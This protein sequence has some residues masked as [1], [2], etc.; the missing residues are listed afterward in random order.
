MARQ[1]TETKWT[2]VW[3]AAIAVLAAAGVVLAERNH[4]LPIPPWALPMLALFG[5]FATM[6]IGL[7]QDLR[8]R[9]HVHRSGAWLAVGAWTTW[10]SIAGWSTSA[11]LTLAGSTVILTALTPL[12]RTPQPVPD[13]RGGA[14]IV[15]PPWDGQDRRPH[16]VR[17][18]ENLLRRLTR[19]PVD[20]SRVEPWAKPKDGCRVFIDLPA[21]GDLT[22]SDLAGI[23]E[24]VATAR[25]LPNGCSVRLLPGEH[26]GE[27]VLDVMLRDCLVDSVLLADD[28][29][30]ASVYDEF[31]VMTTPRGE[32]L[33]VCL[34]SQ[35]MVIGA[36]PD[37]G[38]TT[39]LH[40]IMLFLARC[41]DAV[42]WVADT[43]GGGAATPF[44]RP[45][46]LGLADRP[47]VDWV[48]ADEAEAAVMMAVAAA[49][50]KDRKTA[51]EA[52]RRRHDQ[53][54]T[55]LP[56]DRDLPAI[57]VLNDEGGELRQA[58]NL[59]GQLADQGVS[60]LAQIGR[61][62]AVR[63]I[64]SVL[65]GTSDLLDKGMRVCAAL[66][67]AL[68]MEEQ[69][70]YEHILGVNPGKTTLT[71][72]GTG[73]IRRPGDARPIHGRTVN[74]LLSQ[75]ERAAVACA[76][77]RPPLDERAR[78]AAARVRA[79]DV[80]GGKDPRDFPD[81]MS[82]PALA[83][84]QLGRAYEG[85]WDRFADRL[86]AMRGED[87]PEVDDEPEPAPATELMATASAPP[88]GRAIAHL[89]DVSGVS[90]DATT[91]VQPTAAVAGHPEPTAAPV[92]TSHDEESADVLLAGLEQPKLTTREHIVMI[93][94]D[95][96]PEALT[97]GQIGAELER[98]TGST[99]DRTHRQNLLKDMLERGQILRVEESA[100]GGRYTVKR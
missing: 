72:K 93:L 21:T 89:V 42:I 59:L 56:V 78:R 27:A 37:M 68:R 22:P 36:A 44:V 53:D 61:A 55:V 3:T 40:R 64:K 16:G 10:V 26:Q 66:R 23:V 19:Q 35:S 4:L 84:A 34:R 15:T 85:R 6:L 88:T 62:E 71:H 77:L 32:A 29:T 2:P 86:A 14:V 54:T 74:V 1:Q 33:T 73:F 51:P 17:E 69:D 70:E 57:V 47:L 63:V 91:P 58:A 99:G 76:H 13:S 48:A 79:R 60:R 75:I 38:K 98:R 87:V 92:Q 96:H 90:H 20:V 30:P 45:W 11:W 28:F 39:L 12:C 65:R 52:V 83:D 80:L 9:T 94:G 31:T 49:I 46:A 43:N 81:L 50:A 5:A 25:K 24:K 82:L 67:I 100:N 18:W 8:L 97:A 41:T 95:V 7:V